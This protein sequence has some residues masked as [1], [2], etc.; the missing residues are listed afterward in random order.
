MFRLPFLFIFTG[1][2]SFALFQLFSLFDFAT[3]LTVLGDQPRYPTGWSRIHLLVLGWATMIAMGAVYQLVPVVLQNHGLFSKKLGYVH[4]CFFA[5]GTAGLLIGFQTMQVMMIATFATLAFIGILLFA[6]NIATTLIR[7]NKWDPITISVACSVV[8]LVLG[9]TAGMLMGLNFYFQ[10]WGDFHERLLG[11]HI[12]LAAIGWFGMLI[13]G[14]SYKMLPMFYLSHGYPVRLQK[15]V[16]VLWNAGVLVGASSFLF[17]GPGWLK[18]TGLLL[19]VLA[20]ITYS[21]HLSQMVKHRHKPNPGVGILW[22][23]SIAHCM[24]IIGIILV[25]LIPFIPELI[26]QSRMIVILG[27]LYLWGWIGLTILSYLSKIVPFLWWTHKYGPKIGKGKMPTMS[28][29]IDDR[30][31][32]ITL[33]VIASSLFIL[34]VGLGWNQPM[35][36]SVG[37]SIL[38]LSSLFYIS[39]IGY[40]FAK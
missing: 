30:H 5:I 29:L 20:M 21:Y 19:I 37:G 10:Q 7:A 25:I 31:V 33:S 4:Y 6:F 28:D 15:V 27:W 17:N 40:V 14:L 3:W 13:T 36:T 9:G 34:L 18:W 23:Y 24:T 2:V 32:R 1:L 11:A 16:I 22:S 39:M 35:I 8:Y 12:C 26:V 38:A